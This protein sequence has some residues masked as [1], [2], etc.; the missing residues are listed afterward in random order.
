MG[1]FGFTYYVF[2]IFRLIPIELVGNLLKLFVIRY[3]RYRSFFIVQI[4]L[5]SVVTTEA[6][7]KPNSGTRSCIPICLPT[8]VV[9]PNSET[10]ST[11][12]IF[13]V[14]PSKVLLKPVRSSVVLQQTC[15]LL[16]ALNTGGH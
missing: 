9:V 11:T 1:R 15:C 8:C 5:G 7:Y 13:V 6:I 4:A 10:F 16:N 14:I 3:L 12:D 2:F